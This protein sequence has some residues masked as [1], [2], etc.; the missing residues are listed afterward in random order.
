MR[1]RGDESPGEAA[2]SNAIDSELTAVDAPDH[3][4]PWEFSEGSRRRASEFRE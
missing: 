1:W 2:R 4:V 3:T